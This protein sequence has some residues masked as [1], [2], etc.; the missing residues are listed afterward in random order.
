[1]PTPSYGSSGRQTEMFSE[2]TPH[3]GLSRVPS[4]TIFNMTEDANANKMPGQLENSLQVFF[5]NFIT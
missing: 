1:M 2:V 3:R 5:F 4:E